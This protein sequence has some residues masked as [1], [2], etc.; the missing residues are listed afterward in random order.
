MSEYL[1]KRQAMEYL[2]L[3]PTSYRSI[4]QYIK[5]GLPVFIIGNKPRFSKKA[6]DSFMKDHKKGG[7]VTCK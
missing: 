4:D 2:G 3:A 7:E 1:S 5:E 6:I